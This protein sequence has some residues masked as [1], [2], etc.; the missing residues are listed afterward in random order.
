MAAAGTMRSSQAGD[1]A[2]YFGGPPGLPAL[3]EA[4]LELGTDCSPA[5]SMAED[6]D[7]E[8]EVEAAGERLHQLRAG[9]HSRTH[10][11]GPVVV[12]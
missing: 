10:N 11:H 2:A 1:G 8:L 5:S 4:K 3:P 12:C 7:Q 6:E 9:K